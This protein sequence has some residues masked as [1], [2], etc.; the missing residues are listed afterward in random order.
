VT[1]PG[2]EIDFED[3]DPSINTKPIE[4]EEGGRKFELYVLDMQD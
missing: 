4:F 1:E 3:V 2:F